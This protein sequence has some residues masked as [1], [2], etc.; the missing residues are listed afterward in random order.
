MI[1][2]SVIIGLGFSTIITLIIP[3]V[4]SIYCIFSKNKILKSFV[5]GILVF[6]ISQII[7]RIPIISYIL[8][9]QIWYMKLSLNPYLYGIFLGLT[10]GIFEEIGRYIGFKYFLKSNHRYIDG[11]YFGFGHWG[12]EALLLVGINA[13]IFLFGTIAIKS[14]I[15]YSSPSL[16]SLVSSKLS[17]LTTMNTYIMGIER[18]LTMSIHVSFT[19]IVLYGIRINKIRYLFLAILL[20]G[21]VD[22]GV[23]ILP[24]IFNIN[25]VGMEIYVLIWVLILLYSIFIFKDVFAKL[26]DK[27]V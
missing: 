25:I 11:L 17:S 26:E 23:V 8:P 21:L 22:A 15:D 12:I 20:H 5:V 4:I 7:L 9:N 27:N 1:E 10:A 14:G 16:L 13:A 2:N 19:M 3:I 24:Q 6:F 18:L